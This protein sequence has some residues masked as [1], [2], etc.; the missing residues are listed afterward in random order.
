MTVSAAEDSGSVFSL[1]LDCGSQTT[2]FNST[3]FVNTCSRPG[4][5]HSE[6]KRQPRPHR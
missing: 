4:S 3:C 6:G 5:T 2:L 1:G